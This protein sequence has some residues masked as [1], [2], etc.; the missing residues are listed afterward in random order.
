MHWSIVL[1]LLSVHVAFTSGGPIRQDP[2]LGEQVPGPTH[3]FAGGHVTPAQR[4]TEMHLPEIH[5]SKVAGFPSVQNAP[6][7]WNPYEHYA[8]RMQYGQTTS[9]FEYS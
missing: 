7:G 1:V 8:V 4:F 5:W 6:S 2:F 3:E 9:I